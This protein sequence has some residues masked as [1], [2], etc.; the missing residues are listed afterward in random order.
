[1]IILMMFTKQGLWSSFIFLGGPNNCKI[2]KSRYKVTS[3]HALFSTVY[4]SFTSHICSSDT[5]EILI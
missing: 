4:V 1:M 3:N 2:N 5:F